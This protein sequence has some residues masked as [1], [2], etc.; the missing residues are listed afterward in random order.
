MRLNVLTIAISL[1]GT[2][3]LPLDHYKRDLTIIE[4]SVKQ[5]SAALTTLDN[6]LKG[7]KPTSDTADQQK[8]MKWLLGMDSKV[9]S[10]M[11]AGSIKIRAMPNI[12]AL[13]ATRLVFVMEPMLRDTRSTMKGWV[14]IKAIAQSAGMVTTVRD[15]LSRGATECSGYADAIISRLPALNRGIG[16]SF[17]SSIMSPIDNTI[18]MYA[19]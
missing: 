10:A 17:K 13:D 8:Y 11:A 14:N 1:G 16:Q 4:S 2:I 9:Q 6:A 18:R 3:A 12:N 7:E 19:G 5:V 15:Q